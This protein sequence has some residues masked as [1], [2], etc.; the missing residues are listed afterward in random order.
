MKKSPYLDFVDNEIYEGDTLI[1]PSGETGK[2]VFLEN[3]PR[4]DDQWRVDYGT[5][6]LSR[7]CMQIGDK[8]QAIVMP[9]KR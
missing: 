7:L 9:P 6:D 4:P 8:G 5:N 3:E 1:H 2:V